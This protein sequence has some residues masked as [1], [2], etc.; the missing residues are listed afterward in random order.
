MKAINTKRIVAL[1]AGAAM[2]GATIFGAVA[3]DLSTYPAPF[4]TN[5]TFDGAIVVGELAKSTD[6][7]GSIELAAG[8]QA[9]AVKKTTVSLGPSSSIIDKGVKIDKT[10]THLEY[11]KYLTYVQ[12]TPLDNTDLPDLLAA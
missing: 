4:V 1:T 6:V 8:L 7:V 3:A 10:G 11:G 12:D 2:V 9:A 5:G